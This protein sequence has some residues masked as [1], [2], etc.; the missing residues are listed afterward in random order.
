MQAFF[1][2][3]AYFLCRERL[4]CKAAKWERN[5]YVLHRGDEQY[6]CWLG[7]VIC[8]T[9]QRDSDN[10]EQWA[11]SYRTAQNLTVDLKS[12]FATKEEAIRAIEAR[13]KRLLWD[14]MAALESDNGAELE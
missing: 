7:R 9:V 14:A 11:A 10:R 3:T 4:M 6:R 5:D 2:Q 1:V 13:A 12:R 8:L